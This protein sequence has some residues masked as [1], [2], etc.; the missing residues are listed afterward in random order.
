MGDDLSQIEAYK[1]EQD[2]ITAQGDVMP[3][4]WEGHGRIKI[5]ERDDLT[6]RGREFA[7]DLLA[8]LSAKYP[9]TDSEKLAGKAIKMTRQKLD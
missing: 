5:M 8:R 9:D 2:E 6:R 7:L 1:L 3:D 4:W